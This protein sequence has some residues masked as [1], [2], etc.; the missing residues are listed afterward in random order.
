MAS[1]GDEEDEWDRVKNQATNISSGNKSYPIPF[2]PFIPVNKPLPK[3]DLEHVLTHTRELWEQ[4]RGGRIFIVGADHIF[5]LRKTVSSICS[6]LTFALEMVEKSYLNKAC[7]KKVG[8][9]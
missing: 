5:Q 3:E 9:T 4:L 8:A 1:H 7:N 2:I 6:S